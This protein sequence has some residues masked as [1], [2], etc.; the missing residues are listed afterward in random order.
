MD[1]DSITIIVSSSLGIEGIERKDSLAYHYMTHVSGISFNADGS[2]F[3]SCQDST[4]RYGQAESWDPSQDW[5][6]KNVNVTDSAAESAEGVAGNNFMGPSLWRTATYAVANQARPGV[7]NKDDNG[8]SLYGSHIDM[9]HQSPRC[10]GIT[11]AKSPRTYFAVDDGWGNPIEHGAV[12]RYDFSADHGEGGSNHTVA[13][14]H[15][16]RGFLLTRVAGVAS[17]AVLDHSSNMLFVADTGGSRVVKI[18]LDSGVVSNDIPPYTIQKHKL[19]E[20]RY[21]DVGKH[22]IFGKDVLEHPSGIAVRTETTTGEVLLFVSDYGTSNIHVFFASTGEVARPPVDVSAKMTVRH[23]LSGITFATQGTLLWA[24][25]ATSPAIV[26]ISIPAISTRPVQPVPTPED[27]VHVVVKAPSSS[28]VPNL[29]PSPSQTPSQTVVMMV[30]S[31]SSSYL[32]D[33]TDRTEK[34]KKEVTGTTMDVSGGSSVHVLQHTCR[35]TLSSVVV[36]LLLL[37]LQ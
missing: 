23:G 21:V 18:D 8:K 6:W 5:R 15:R 16:L 13:R 4:N 31:S 9:L 7:W 26:T 34:E 2:E 10:V 33:R 35:R 24:T 19:S 1:N 17:Q 14:V 30:P 25:H 37:L 28:D 32:S 20:Y 3:A 27:P 12:V 36:V 22:W 29:V 11:F